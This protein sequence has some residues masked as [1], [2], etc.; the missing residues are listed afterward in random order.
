MLIAGQ[1]IR[2][3]ELPV[4]DDADLLAGRLTPVSYPGVPKEAA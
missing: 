2:K 1:L 3:P 4:G